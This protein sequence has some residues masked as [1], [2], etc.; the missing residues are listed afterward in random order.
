[1]RS[2]IAVAA[3]VPRLAVY[4]LLGTG[5]LAGAAFG[6]EQ[7]TIDGS[8]RTE[9]WSGE[10]IPCSRAS[11]QSGRLSGPQLLRSAMACFEE[12]NSF[13]GTFLPI[14]GQIRSSTDLSL[15][16]AAGDLDEVAMGEL[17]GA[18]FYR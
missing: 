17:Y 14:A 16:P 9:L 2:H 5:A 7:S 1:M 6:A 4:L 3:Q 11:E 13:D 18:I 15:L 8:L 10:V 12:G